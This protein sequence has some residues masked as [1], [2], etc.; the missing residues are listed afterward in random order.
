MVG[1]KAA[2]FYLSERA[3]AEEGVAKGPQAS[4]LDRLLHLDISRIGEVLAFLLEDGGYA[5]FQASDALLPLMSERLRRTLDRLRSP[6]D[7]LE[8][9]PASIAKGDEVRPYFLLRVPGH[10]EVLD[11]KLTLFAGGDFVVRAVLDRTAATGRN[12][13]SFEAAT[14]RIIVSG[15]VRVRLQEEALTGLVFEKVRLAEDRS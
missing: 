1:E 5:D 10:P 12:V 11:A 15:S 14:H 2:F 9:I 13:F 3:A 7:E 6:R 8:W 4:E